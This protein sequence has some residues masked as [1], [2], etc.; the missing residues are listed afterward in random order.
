MSS[1]PK[2]LTDTGKWEKSWIRELDPKHKLF[3]VWLWDRVNYAGIWEVDFERIRFELGMNLNLEEL[4][5]VF[6]D[7]IVE[8]DNGEKWFYPSFI[9][10]QYKVPVGQL[11][12]ENKAHLAV[13]RALIK[14]DLS[15]TWSEWWKGA[16]QGLVRG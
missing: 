2:R 9:E 13:I 10:F 1:M 12:P 6:K 7:K 4:R 15:P 14:H 16:G 8:F 3:L 5:L 11:N